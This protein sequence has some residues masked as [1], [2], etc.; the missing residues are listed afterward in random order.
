MCDRGRLFPF[1]VLCVLAICSP[2]VLLADT[3]QEVSI[4]VGEEFTVDL[5]SNPSTGYEWVLAESLPNWLE[6]VQKS[7]VA[8]NPGTIGGAA[9]NTGYSGRQLPETR[10]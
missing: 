1:V 9:R 6:L 2:S 3:Y 8:T 5:A 7:Y 4:T 10:I